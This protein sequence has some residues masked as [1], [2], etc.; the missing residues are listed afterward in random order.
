DTRGR[1]AKEMTRPEENLHLWKLVAE[2]HGCF[3]RP[4]PFI[5]DQA[6]FLFYRDQ[7]SSLHYTPHVDY[8][9]SVTL[10]SG[11]PGAGKD[12]WLAKRR[13]ETP[14]VALDSI[15]DALDIEA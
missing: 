9:C 12:T 2:E 5:N 7:L 15:R 10:M 14:V 1:Q 3:A 6:R 4:Y 8:R 11:L 13:R